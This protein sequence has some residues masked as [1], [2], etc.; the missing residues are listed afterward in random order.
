MFHLFMKNNMYIKVHFIEIFLLIFFYEK[1]FLKNNLFQL[2]D[3][4][5][6]N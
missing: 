5:I 4:N 3:Y 2:F 6:K 1:Y